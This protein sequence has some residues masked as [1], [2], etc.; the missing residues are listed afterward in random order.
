MADFTHILQIFD[1]PNPS[2]RGEKLYRATDGV[3]IGLRKDLV[4]IFGADPQKRK[5]L[6]FIDAGSASRYLQN[7]VPKLDLKEQNLEIEP[8]VKVE[9]KNS[10][11][12]V[13][14][15]SM[16]QTPSA[17]GRFQH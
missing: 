11:M 13:L 15:G 10:G 3:Y 8:N 6:E 12:I 4:V 16:V 17:L 1:A 9:Q 2:D 5:G 14:A 7:E